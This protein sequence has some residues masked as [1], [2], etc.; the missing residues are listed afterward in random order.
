VTDVLNPVDIERHIRGISNR[1]ANGVP[2]V[3]KSYAE[4][5]A[6]DRA[7]DRAFA[8]AYMGHNGPAHERKYAAELETEAEREARD[9]ADVAHRYA[10][11]Q[12][13]AL[14]EELRAYQSVGAS[15]RAMFSIAGRGE[16]M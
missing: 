4:Y 9:I 7:Y 10:K 16:G 3:S 8:L 5:L 2:V 1:I 6:K 12:A 15:V 14:R 11:D 13:E